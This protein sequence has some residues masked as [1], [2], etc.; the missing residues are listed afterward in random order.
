MKKSLSVFLAIVFLGACIKQQETE[1]SNN[2]LYS[3][4]WMQTAAEYIANSVMTYQAAAAFL[5]ELINDKK[6][7]ALP[8]QKEGFQELPPAIILDVDETVLD[9]SPY[10]GKLVMENKPFANDTWNHWLSL[11][12]AKAIPG[13]VDFL[14]KA[15]DMGVTIFY[16]TNRR[17]T[18]LDNDPCPQDQQ[19][20]ENLK[21][22]GINNVNKENVLLRDEQE[23]WGRDKTSRREFV[24][25][26]YRVIMLFGDNLADFLADTAKTAQQRAELIN[27]NRQRWGNSWFMLA[28]PSYGGWQSVLE[29]PQETHL[30]TY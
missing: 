9:N 10:Q 15:Q 21:N 4:L 12:Q 30:V 3:T 18:A 29:K 26:N 11:K 19:T 13:A 17:C 6:H 14:N 24:A 7:S 1:F 2:N 8:Q 20:F 28:N 16:V 27:Q 22:V 23:E 25:E 5:P